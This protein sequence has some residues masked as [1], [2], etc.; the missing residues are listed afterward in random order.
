MRYPIVQPKITR[1]FGPVDTQQYNDYEGFH[2]GLDLAPTTDDHNIYAPMNAL[3]IAVGYNDVWGNFFVLLNERT[4]REVGFAHCES[5]A[6]NV[7]ESVKLS[8]VIGVVGNTGNSF[9][10]HLH[11]NTNKPGETSIVS[12][13]NTMIESKRRC[14]D[15]LPLFKD[16]LVR[17]QVRGVAKETPQ[18]IPKKKRLVDRIDENPMIPLRKKD[19]PKAQ[20]GLTAKSLLVSV[21]ARVGVPAGV[22][23]VFNE[24]VDYLHLGENAVWLLTIALLL[25]SIVGLKTIE[26][27][28][29]FRIDFNMDGKYEK[30]LWE[31]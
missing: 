18:F 10:I 13:H 11:I 2:S 3:V 21:G 20:E 6:V 9:G 31:K 7:G 4:G 25:L 1:G 28:I 16:E 26:A 27:I 5:V 12:G 24:Y 17:E 19:A 30:K 8:K 22:I 14:E 15:P 23:K 29:P